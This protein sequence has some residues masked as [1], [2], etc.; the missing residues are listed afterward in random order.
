[1]TKEGPMPTGAPIPPGPIPPAPIPP[2][3]GPA[4]QGGPGRRRAFARRAGAAAA[5]LAAAGLVLGL[6]PGTA[7][8]GG[9]PQAACPSGAVTEVSDTADPLSAGPAHLTAGYY[10]VAGSFFPPATLRLC[11]TVRAAD[12]PLLRVGTGTCP[13]GS[14]AFGAPNATPPAYDSSD[15]VTWGT[16]LPA[17]WYSSGHTAPSAAGDW[18][19]V[20][21]SPRPPAP[22]SAL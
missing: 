4:A 13:A 18:F 17:G 20:C 9:T 14:V 8:A 3:Q 11:R 5:T 19:T 16:L 7:L 22:G 21:W 1:M 10:A 12:H 6:G 15:A 2:A